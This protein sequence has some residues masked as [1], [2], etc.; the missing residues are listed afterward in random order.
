MKLIY[1]TGFVLIVLFSAFCSCES[2]ENKWSD[3]IKL[4]SKKV[5]LSADSD[6]AVFFTE[7]DWWWIND[8]SSDGSYFYVKADD[9]DKDF[10]TV[11]GNWFSVEKSGKHKLIVKVSENKSKIDRKMVIT[12]ESGNYFDYINVYQKAKE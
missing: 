6:S 10:I 1:N 4:S 8:V 2:N 7:G 5:E 11:E 3:T 12:L 9:Y